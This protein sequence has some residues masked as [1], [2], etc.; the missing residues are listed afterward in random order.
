MSR[1]FRALVCALLVLVCAMPVMAQAQNT[2]ARLRADLESGGI[3]SDDVVLYATVAIMNPALLPERYA[4]A[5]D[6]ECANELIALL[7]EHVRKTHPEVRATVRYVFAPPNKRAKMKKPVIKSA[8]LK[9]P[10]LAEQTVAALW[11]PSS[12]LYVPTAHFRVAYTL[13]G[14]DATTLANAQKVGNYLELAY[15]AYSGHGFAMPAA[16][17]DGKID[18]I[19]KANPCPVDVGIDCGNAGVAIPPSLS[20]LYDGDGDPLIMISNGSMSDAFLRTLAAHELFHQVQYQTAGFLKMFSSWWVLEGQASAMEDIVWPALNTYLD[21]IAEYYATLQQPLSFRSYD[22]AIFWKYLMMNHSGNNPSIIRDDLNGVAATDVYQGLYNTLTARGSSLEFAMHQFGLWNLFAGSRFRSGY[23]DD[24]NLTGWGQVNDFLGDHTMGNVRTVPASTHYI[25]ALSVRYVRVRPDSSVTSNRKLT[26]KAHG[27]STGD[28]RG[29]VVHR[30]VNGTVSIQD[31]NLQEPGNSAVISINDFSVSNTDEVILVFTNGFEG[32]ALPFDYELSLPTSLDLAF[33]MDTTGSMSGSITALKSTATSAMTTLGS[34][35]ADF[36]IAIT[37]FK[38]FPV[39]PYGSTGDFPY[40]A[41]SPFSNTPSVILGGIN[42]LSASGGGDWPESKLSGVMGAINANGITAWRSGSKKAIVVMTDAP[43]HNP[44]PFTGYTIAS[45]T[46]AAQAGGVTIPAL[47]TPFQPATLAAAAAATETP[48]RIYGVVVGGDWEAHYYLSQLAT[49]TGGKVWATS[50][51]TGDIAEA[52]LEAIGEIS[53]G[54][55]PGDP[56]PPPGN[57]APNVSAAIAD[58][59]QLWPANNK[60]VDVNITNVTDPDGDSVT[61]SITGI[62]Q[63]ESV[64][65]HENGKE[66]D[67]EGIGTSTARVRAERNGYAN[68][69]VYVISFTATDSRGA[70]ASGSVTVCVPHDQGGNTVCTDDGQSF[71]STEP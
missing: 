18:V 48:I 52:I 23:Y 3:T 66:V 21:D 17:N 12:T 36:R 32:A 26:V 16:P 50:Y 64:N 31:M 2:A 71:T 20:T 1:L 4:G 7:S 15:S 10:A 39:W 30:R 53:E 59:S 45:V 67:G 57:Q 43:P 5:V 40:R 11:D 61:I 41:N 65:H 22:A 60:M 42:M 6:H 63:D 24:A 8:K 51:N 70:S 14:G 46:A 29:W 13:S 62:T 68:G 25:S 38:D 19:I 28:I 37:E 49:A 55:G 27:I 34:S 47:S 44:E 58:P 69:R 9:H 54:G 56:P 35:G 33:C